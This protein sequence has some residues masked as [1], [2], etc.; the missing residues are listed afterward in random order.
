MNSYTFMGIDL[1]GEEVTSCPKKTFIKRA[2]AFIKSRR[3]ANRPTRNIITRDRAGANKR[4]EPHFKKLNRK[5]ETVYCVKPLPQR[6]VARNSMH[7]SVISDHE[8]HF[9]SC[10]LDFGRCW[11]VHLPMVEFSYNNNYHF[12]VRRAPFEALYGRK[13]RSPILWTD[14]GGGQ[15]IRPEIVHETTDKISQ[16]RMSLKPHVIVRKEPVELLRRE[17]KKLK[18]S[19]IPIA[20]PVFLPIISVQLEATY[21]EQLEHLMVLLECYARSTI[22]PATMTKEAT[23][24]RARLRVAMVC[25]K[26]PLYLFFCNCQVTAFCNR[27]SYSGLGLIRWAGYG[28]TFSP[29]IANDVT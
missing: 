12:S 19:R 7:V 13:C 20:K 14:V 3:V 16:I 28:P 9:R 1:D 11:D 25:V 29:L 15:L 18:R 6:I 21:V 5:K 2:I 22:L 8:G 27:Q 24:R 4:L 26:E 17:I 23:I 10:V